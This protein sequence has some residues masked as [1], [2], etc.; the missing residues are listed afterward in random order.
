MSQN[1]T[2]LRWSEARMF[3]KLIRI[4]FESALF[5]AAQLGIHYS[6][7]LTLFPLQ[8]EMHFAQGHCKDTQRKILIERTWQDLNLR[9]HDP[10]MLPYCFATTAV[11]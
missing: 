2:Q 8:I 1:A 10:E 7:G 3:L 11:R 9:P 4:R 6:L 5:Q